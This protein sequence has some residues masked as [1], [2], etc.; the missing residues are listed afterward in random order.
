MIL[1]TWTNAA[2]K[3][4][5]MSALSDRVGTHHAYDWAADVAKVGERT[6][7]EIARVDT[8]W[9]KSSVGSIH[10]AMGGVGVAQA[11]YG[12]T[13]AHPFYT[14]FQEYGTRHGIKPMHSLIAGHKAMEVE[15]QDAGIRMLGRINK[16]WNSI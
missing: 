16:E 15:A 10:T 14:K 4:A 8:G 3:A 12:L 6:I 5:G 7:E 13:K 1:I 11:G 2:Q 9:M